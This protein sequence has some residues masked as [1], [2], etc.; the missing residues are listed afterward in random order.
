LKNEFICIRIN[1]LPKLEIL[2]F[3]KNMAIQENITI[4]DDT[5]NKIQHLFK[6]DIRSMINYI[7][8]NENVLNG[9]EGLY[10]N[11]DTL[12]Q[13]HTLITDLSIDSGA[14]VSFIR[15][16]S[17]EFN[18]DERSIVQKYI[19]HLIVNYPDISNSSF[20]QSIEII[21]HRHNIP[22]RVHILYLFSQI[23]SMM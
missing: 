8:L 20:I 9:K 17:I 22:L 2:K 7:Q 16:L 12:E 4:K 15:K 18:V 5:I 23:R 19:N 14:F 10:M 11:E 21:I 1:Q 3:I 13:I 6:S